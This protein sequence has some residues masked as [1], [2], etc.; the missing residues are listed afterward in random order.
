MIG[1]AL[2]EEHATIKIIE[3]NQDKCTIAVCE[4]WSML[5]RG[6]NDLLLVQFKRFMSA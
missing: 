4:G 5:N 6:H 1:A 3:V 2:I